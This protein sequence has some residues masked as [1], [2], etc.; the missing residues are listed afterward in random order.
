MPR[1]IRLFLTED[2]QLRSL[3]DGALVIGH[4]FDSAGRPAPDQLPDSLFDW[5]RASIVDRYWGNYLAMIAG[6]SRAR[7]L[8]DPSGGLAAYHAMVGE[9]LYLTSAP[10]LLIDCGVLACDLDWEV[11]ARSL[12]NHDSRGSGTALRGIVELMPGWAMTVGEDAVPACP[13]WNPWVSASRERHCD[14]ASILDEA[15][16]TTLAAW[17]RTTRRPLIEISGGLDS[18]IVAAGVAA[19]APDASLITFAPAPGD[20]DETNYAR[21]LAEHLSLPLEIVRP[22]VN[23]VDLARS[24]GRDLPRPNA[25]AFVQAADLMSL[26]YARAIGADAF[27][28]GGGGDDV[29]CYLRTILPAIDR[30]QAEGVRAMLATCADIA[31]VNHATVW[32][33]YWKVARRL[34]RGSGRGPRERPGSLHISAQPGVNQTV[35]TTDLSVPPGKAAHV[36]AVLSIHN[37]LEGHRRAAFA[38]IMSPLLSQPIVE[39]CLSIPTWSWC[40]NG[41]NRAVARQA[42]AGRLPPLLLQRRSKGSFDGFCAQ[43]FDR[44]RGLIR[45]MLLD[46]HLARQGLI[47]RDRV[48]QALREPFPS[49]EVSGRILALVDA[50]SWVGAWVD[51]PTQRG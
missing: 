35:A 20:P 33:A 46:G 41:Q 34:V 6:V 24:I 25:R 48:D 26:R 21:A 11:I 30:L 37:Y 19:A 32:D 12:S 40:A 42:F 39:C 17:G 2:L 13:I 51:R 5:E 23:D 28:S 14:D 27:F 43:L 36:E 22:Q 9:T 7:L 18:A 47:D 8:R 31:A 15:L 4:L 10:H 29:F 44:R 49:S 45:E 16:T 38:P 3:G 50:E 1:G